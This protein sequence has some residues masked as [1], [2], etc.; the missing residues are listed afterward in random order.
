MSTD[1]ILD[2]VKKMLALGNCEGATEAER[3]TALRMA[4]NLL[5]KHNL[6]ISDLPSDEQQEDREQQ[7]VSLCADKWA[8]SMAQAVAKLFFCSYYYSKTGKSRRDIHYFVGKQSNAGTARYMAEYV[9]SSVKREASKRYGAANNPEGRSF[10]VGATNSIRARV[11]DM[12]KQ[13]TESTPGTALVLINLHKSEAIENDKW[14]ATVAQVKL[15]T[16]KPRADNSLRHDAFYDG[17]DYG[18]TV[19]L[20]PQVTA[21]KGAKQLS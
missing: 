12:V 4:Y 14:L 1:K 20:N 3:E 5:A 8:R 16:S 13:A 17:R 19:S 9:I 11:N 15:K 6:S 18:K 10:C 21:G 7:E 2:R